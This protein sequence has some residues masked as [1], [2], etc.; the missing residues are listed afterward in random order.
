MSKP[1]AGAFLVPG[2][3]A[4]KAENRFVFRV[5]GE[6]QD[7]SLPLLRHIKASYRRRLSEVSR[8]LKDGSVSEDTRALAR[9]EGE[10]IQFEIIE[11]CCP[12]LTDVVSSDQLEAI[13]TAWG[14]ASGTSVGESSAS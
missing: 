3:K 9:L 10:S 7:R 14:E 5:P 11:D 2:A 13:I 4:E 8:R 12:G 1:A 6:K